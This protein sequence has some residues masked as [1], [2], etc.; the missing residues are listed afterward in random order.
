MN[1]IRKVIYMAESENKR[2]RRTPQERAAEVDCKIEK[3]KASIA[4]LEE[5][6]QAAIVDYDAKIAAAQDRIKGLEGKKQEILAPKPPRKQRKTKKQKIQE[7][8]KLALKNGMSVDEI[9]DQLH[10]EVEN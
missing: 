7:I 3:V 9:A 5:K 10:V 2:P 1:S 6:K 8:V 4:E